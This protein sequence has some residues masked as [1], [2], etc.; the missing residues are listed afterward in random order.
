[1]REVFTYNKD[2]RRDPFV[3]LLSTG[4]LRP[5][6]ADLKLMG[7]VLDISGRHSIAVMRDAVTNQQ[8]RVTTGQQIGRMR[9]AQIKRNTVVFTIEEFGMNRQDSLVLNDTTKVRAK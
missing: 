5:T 4:E 3:S 9:V 6:I 2:S 8:Y 1:M 7:I